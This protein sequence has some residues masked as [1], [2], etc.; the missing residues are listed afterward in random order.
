MDG[1]GGG[2]EIA[3]ANNSRAK[4]LAYYKAYLYLVLQLATNTC[5]LLVLYCV[6][7]AV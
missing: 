7:V 4:C 2:M 1:M 6:I 5:I 3:L